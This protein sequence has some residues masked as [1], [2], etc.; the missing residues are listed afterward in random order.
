MNV[1]F[2]QFL[3]ILIFYSCSNHA[4]INVQV[5]DIDSHEPIDSV[6][7]ILHRS[8]LTNKN[9]GGFSGQT[10]SLGFANFLFTKDELDTYQHMIIAHK[11]GYFQTEK[12]DSIIKNPKPV[13]DIELYLSSVETEWHR[14]LQY[15]NNDT[16]R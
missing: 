3:F 7:I 12:S 14:Q 6:K 1:I 4:S 16:I 10:D 5:F 13:N 11:E 2:L 8:D 9:F 15:Y